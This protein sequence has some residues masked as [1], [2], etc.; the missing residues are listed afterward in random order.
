MLGEV[1]LGAAHD[2]GWRIDATRARFLA[3]SLP[4]WPV[5]PDTVPALRRLV[6][7]GYRLGILSNIDDDLLS[8]T[9]EQLPV[10]FSLLVTAERV[11]S[12]K[13]AAGH[14]AAAAEALGDARWLHAAQSC[15]HDVAPAR[16][17]GIPVVWINR[18]AEAP[19]GDAHPD[20]EFK[21]LAALADFMIRGTP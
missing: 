13:P 6:A 4:D 3:R 11:R 14:F 15:F 17:R 9:L 16:E 12:Y 1:A 5:F 10:E 21:D 18:K 20:Y 19:G 2:L 7:A 8:G